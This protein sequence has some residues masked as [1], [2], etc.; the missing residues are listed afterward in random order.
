MAAAVAPLSFR[1]LRMSVTEHCN[2]RCTYCMP[3]RNLRFAARAATLDVS[4][5]TRVMRVLTRAGVSKLRITGGEPLL[6]ADLPQ[7]IAAIAPLPGLRELALTSNGVLLGGRAAQLAAAGLQRVN[8]SLDSLDAAQFERITRGGQLRD[9]LHGIEAACRAGLTPVK[10]NVVVMRGWNAHE[11]PAF[12]ELALSQP[13]EVRFIERMPVGPLGELGDFTSE[14]EMRALLA[15]YTLE[16]LPHD[17]SPARRL[18]IRHG[19]REGTI[20]FVSPMSRPF[21]ASCDR[22]RLT[23]QGTLRACLFEAAGVDVRELLRGGATDDDLQ[24]ALE[25]AARLRRVGEVHG[26]RIDAAAMSQL[27]G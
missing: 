25:R 7:L 12:A 5:L 15:G 1:Y 16:E 17:N 27:G 19:A 4:E 23:A 13:V 3:A 10:L 6:R 22:L 9:V 26:A 20:G 18:R 8:I 2:L 14:A 24:Q 11:L 21:C